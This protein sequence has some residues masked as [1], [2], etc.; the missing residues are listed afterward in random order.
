[1]P[2]T[3]LPP[4]FIVLLLAFR[5]SFTAPSFANFQTVVAGWVHCLGRH[6][7]TAVALASG[8]AGQRHVSVFHRFFRRA[9]WSLDALGQVLFTLALRWIPADQSLI[10]LGDDT[11]AH[12][13]GK[14]V[15]LASMHHDPLLSTAQRPFFSFGHVWVVLA[16]WVSLPM[17]P[18]RGFGLPIRVR[19]FTGSKRGGQ[20]GPPSLPPAGRR[21]RAPPQAHA[22]R[23]RRTKLELL[24]EMTAA[25]AR[26]APERTVYLA[27]DSAYAGRTTLED[28]PAN[29]HVLSRLRPDAAL[30]SRPPQRRPGQ[31][32]RPRRRGERLPTPKALAATRRH[33]HRLP[34]TLYGQAVTTLVFGCTALWYAALRD[35]PVRILLVRDPRGRRQL[36]VFFCTDLK[37]SAAAILETYAHRWTLEVTF[38]DSKQFLGFADPQS[39]TSQSVQRTAPLAFVVYDLVL[40]WSAAHGEQLGGAAAWIDRPWYRRKQAPSFLDMLTA[41]RQAGWRCYFSELPLG[42]RQP[43]NSLAA[44]PDAVLATA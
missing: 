17:G 15:S 7:V 29:V 13:S 8:A 35:Q 24:R 36:D 11:L 1:M 2:T 23:D 19:L 12:K 14:S 37:L 44:W 43:Q 32:G 28:R 18:L 30:W 3:I 10:L 25:V 40:L 39:Q 42:S 33:W 31:K 4:T 38:R 6:T 26:W 22:Q 16:L 21:R 20:V 9:Q 41:L 27:V 34:V 5:E